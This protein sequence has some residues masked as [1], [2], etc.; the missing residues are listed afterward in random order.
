MCEKFKLK[1]ETSETDRP[2]DQWTDSRGHGEVNLPTIHLTECAGKI[3]K[4]SIIE[5]YDPHQYKERL[6][7]HTKNTG[8]SLNIVFSSKNS[9]KFA[10]SLTRQH[11]AAIG[12]TKN[13]QPIGLYTR[14]ASRVSYSDVGEGGLAVKCE[15]TQFF[16]NTLYYITSLN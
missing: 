16:I 13:Y 1:K 8:C 12:C 10:T 15:K 6:L 3:V 14:I 2:T 11:S 5:T 7:L 9:R 4:R